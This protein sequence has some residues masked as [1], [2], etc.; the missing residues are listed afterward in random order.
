MH[1]GYRADTLQLDAD[2]HRRAV[3]APNSMQ[4]DTAPLPDIVETVVRRQR[5]AMWEIVETLV[6]ALL[7]FVAVRSVVLNFRVDGLSMEPSLASGQ[8]LLVNR[9][10]YFHFDVNRVLGAVPFVDRDGERIVYLFHPPQRGD[11][12]VL[13]PP[14]NQGKPYIKRVVALPGERV[15][16]RDGAVYI[17]GERLEE[18]YLNGVATSWGGSL[19]QEEITIPEGRVFVMGDNRNNS[20]DSRSFGAV[21]IDEIIGKAWISYWPTDRIRFI[22]TP[23]Y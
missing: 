21:E 16:I 11:I 3:S 13:H 20:T 7:I 17:N 9:Q 4:G 10:V 2:R 14:V 22:S 5:S 15:A 19:G 23:D 8:M 6:L 12:V 18:E 1:D